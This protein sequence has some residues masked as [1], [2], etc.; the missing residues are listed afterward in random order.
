MSSATADSYPESV[1]SCRP[2]SPLTPTPTPPAPPA[3]R[4]ASVRR[5]LDFADADA[6]AGAIA[7][8]DLNVDEFFLSAMDD[9]ERGYS[10]AKR[11][12]PPCVCRRGECA[13]WQ[14]EQSGRWMYVCSAQPKCKYVVLCEEVGL[15]PESQPAVRSNPK[16]SNPYVLTTPSS[17]VPEPA[18]PINIVNLRGAGATTPANVNPQA[19]LNSTFQ[20]AG[21]TTP[22]HVSAQGAGS[23]AVVK[24]SPQ[25]A[26]SKDAW[27]TCKCTA[28]KCKVLRVDGEDYYVCPIPKGQGACNHK[29][30][31][32][33]HAVAND[34]LQTGDD[35]RRGDKDL[36]DKPAEKEAHGNNHLVQLGDNNANG[37][38]NPT[39]ADDNEWLFDVINEE[40][41]PTAEATPRA[42]VHQGSPSML[43]QPI[44][45]E[46]PTK[47]PAPPYSTRSPMT[48]RSNDICFRCREKGHY[49]RDCPKPSPTPRTGCFHCGM[50]GHWVRDCPQL[51]GS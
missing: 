21:T 2:P 9:I 4:G 17:H 1:G 23:A 12:A 47:S 14:D 18:T 15:S 5:Q 46:T 40:I 22:V 41:V 35:N 25:G 43:R 38:V 27:P 3:H 7:G 28:G 24:V 19:P 48:P 6:D 31:V 34:L 33:A 39:H 13:V 29:V 8:G 44:A 26:R 11:R 51:R 16:P 20:G 49:M 36:K 32:H 30:P 10:E 37:T 42:E 45:T 50:D